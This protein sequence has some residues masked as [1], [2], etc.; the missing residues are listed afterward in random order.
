MVRFLLNINPSPLFIFCTISLIFIFSFY[1]LQKKGLRFRLS[2]NIIFL[3]L[4]LFFLFKLIY[5]SIEFIT[6]KCFAI[7]F[8]IFI[9]STSNIKLIFKLTSF[10]PVI[11][12]TLSVLLIIQQVLLQVFFSGMIEKFD[13][14][15]E[16]SFMDRALPV[17]APF[18]LSLIEDDEPK[19]SLGGFNF[20]RSSLFSHEPKFGASILLLTMGV[21]LII[22][23][24]MYTKLLFILVQ[25][26]GLFLIFS[27]AG[28]ICFF[29]SCFMLLIDFSKIR[30]C[31]LYVAI[32]AGF[33]LFILP[34]ILSLFVPSTGF[35]SHRIESLLHISRGTLSQYTLFGVNHSDLDYNMIN[36]NLLSSI[37]LPYG[38]LG[39][40]LFLILFYVILYEPNYTSGDNSM[41]LG[42]ILLFNTFIFFNIYSFYDTLNLYSFTIIIILLSLKI[43]HKTYIRIFNYHS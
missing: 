23:F 25:L 31:F 6:L 36:A 30:N 16:A 32:I 37:I 13:T 22:K 7:S 27:L 24:N 42:K 11:G 43:S 39:L 38:V 40:F 41:R 15:I 21:T 17:K 19:L 26:L 14:V 34:K 29:L 28:L 8:T 5:F 4:S 18:Y 12:F 9:L 20:Y 2:L 3:L 1:Q 33:P 35:I 10:F